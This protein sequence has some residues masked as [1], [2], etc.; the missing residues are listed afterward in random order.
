MGFTWVILLFHIQLEVGL[1]RRSR[2]ELFNW[3]LG[4]RIFLVAQVVKNLPAMQETWVRSLGQ[5]D[6]LEKGMAFHSRTLP[7]SIPGIEEPG[8]LQFMESQSQTQMDD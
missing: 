6:P 3:Y 8:W 7:W 2:M 1:S 4:F 5:E